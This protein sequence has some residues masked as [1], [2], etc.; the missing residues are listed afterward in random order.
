MFLDHQTDKIKLC[1]VYIF[2][3]RFVCE[4]A[5]IVILSRMLGSKLGCLHTSKPLLKKSTGWAVPQEKL[6]NQL[7]LFISVGERHR[8]SRL[9]K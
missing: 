7:K 1:S 9:G 8:C 6:M 3:F 4:G 2:M 5:F